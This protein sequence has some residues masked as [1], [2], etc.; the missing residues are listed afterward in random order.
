MVRGWHEGLI[1]DPAGFLQ[2]V[3]V[4]VV[5]SADDEDVSEAGSKSSDVGFSGDSDGP[6]LGRLDKNDWAGRGV[7][8][9]PLNGAPGIF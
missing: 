7:V 9:Q 6:G 5:Y 3:V 2:F 8:Q 4:V 1:W